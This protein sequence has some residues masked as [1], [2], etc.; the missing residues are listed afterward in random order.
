M[1]V[2]SLSE[3]IKKWCLDGYP[4]ISED[5]RE[6]IEKALVTLFG[7]VKSGDEQARADLKI[8]NSS[9]VEPKLTDYDLKEHFK[10]VIQRCGLNDRQEA[11][12][13][14]KLQSSD[15]F[16]KVPMSRLCDES[17]MIKAVDGETAKQYQERVNSVLERIVT[18]KGQP[19]ELLAEMLKDNP[20]IFYFEDRNGQDACMSEVF[21][22]GKRCPLMIIEK[23]MFNTDKVSEDYLA[24]TMAHELGHWIDFSSRPADYLGKEK[25]W[26]ECF[27]DVSGYQVAKNAGYDAPVMI[28][29]E[30]K[31][32]QE[33]RQREEANGKSLPDETIFEQRTA[34]LKKMFGN[35]ESSLSLTMLQ[36][37][38]AKKHHR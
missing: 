34:L 15:I 12:F 37:Q 24:T 38:S 19:N 3:I 14:E 2:E 35:G 8:L 11:L 1:N 9:F 28:S 13:I 6:P 5:E 22:N 32:A 17:K 7:A 30:E 31:F 18:A 10:G 4:L 25:L 36:M 20:V 16:A 23:G 29:E 27:A 21:L 33:Y 26:Q